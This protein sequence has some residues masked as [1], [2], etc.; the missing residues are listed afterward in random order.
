[1]DLCLRSTNQD[2]RSNEASCNQVFRRATNFGEI[3]ALSR[4]YSRTEIVCFFTVMYYRL[5]AT[6]AQTSNELE[7]GISIYWQQK[8]HGVYMFQIRLI[9]KR[10]AVRDYSQ[11]KSTV[12]LP[13][14]Q[15]RHAATDLLIWFDGKI[16]NRWSECAYWTQS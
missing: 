3:L 12:H 11:W 9:L 8:A 5:R 10:L 7:V 14:G 13:T 6:M 15:L 1:M 4:Y 16:L 2:R